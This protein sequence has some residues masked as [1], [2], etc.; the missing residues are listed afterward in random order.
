MREL[1]IGVEML[2]TNLIWMGCMVYG[3][4]LE[5]PYPVLRQMLIEALSGGVSLR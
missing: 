3:R 2:Q 5:L 1:S 4:N